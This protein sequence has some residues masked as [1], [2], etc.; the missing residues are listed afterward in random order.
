MVD[1]SAR[2]CACHHALRRE[3]DDGSVT[4]AGA[5]LVPAESYAAA[6]ALFQRGSRARTVGA[7]A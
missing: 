1:P 7:I 5:R 2:D 3:A 6:V 4:V